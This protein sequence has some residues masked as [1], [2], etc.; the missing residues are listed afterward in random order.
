MSTTT[1]CAI[2]LCAAAMLVV[3]RGLAAGEFWRAAVGRA[4]ADEAD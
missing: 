3:S 1:V 2:G 4:G